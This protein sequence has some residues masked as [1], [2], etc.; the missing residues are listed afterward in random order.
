[1]AVRAMQSGALFFLEKPFEDQILLDYVN[2][3]LVV[4]K[5]NQ[6]ARIRL[7]TTQARIANLTEREREVL[8][9]VTNNHSNKEI[10]EKLGV[11]IKTVEFHRSH[12][13]EKMHAQSLIDLVNMLREV[14][15][16]GKWGDAPSY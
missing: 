1:M 13:M 6:Q 3:A 12:M 14:E 7:T 10:A 2:E 4:D 9:L 8:D 11:S 5:N 15:L 16:A